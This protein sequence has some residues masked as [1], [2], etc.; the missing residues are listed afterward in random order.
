MKK[1]WDKYG[2]VI[3]AIL[4]LGVI[5][6]FLTIASG[7]LGYN[8]G[9]K[10]GKNQ[11]EIIYTPPVEKEVIDTLYITRYK[12]INKIQYLETVKHDTIQKVYIL[13][14]SSTLELFYKLVSEQY[15]D[16]PR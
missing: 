4:I 16:E 7:Y 3:V 13:D 2:N 15:Y 12:I 1:I 5:P 6:L 10:K 8:L 11:K 14:D 9:Y